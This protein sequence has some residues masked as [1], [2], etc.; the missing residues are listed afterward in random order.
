VKHFSINWTK[1]EEYE[2]SYGTKYCLLMALSRLSNA[3]FLKH[4]MNMNTPRAKIS[5]LEPI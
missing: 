4:S 1:C 3:G 2:V 5:T